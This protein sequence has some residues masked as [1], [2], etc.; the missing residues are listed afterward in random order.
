MKIDIAAS[1]VSVELIYHLIYPGFARAFDLKMDIQFHALGIYKLRLEGLEGQMKIESD[2]KVAF[3]A[4]CI[5]D[6]MGFSS[7]CANKK[8]FSRA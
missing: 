6:I 7:V 2:E 3:I 5:S 8:R 4:L 1:R